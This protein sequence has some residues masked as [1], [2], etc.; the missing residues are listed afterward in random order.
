[1]DNQFNPTQ[2]FQRYV[3]LS[4]LAVSVLVAFVSLMVLMKIADTYDLE[5]KVKSIEY[6]IRIASVALGFVIFA[7]LY[8][9][10]KVNTYMNEVAAELMTKVSWPTV[11]ETWSATFIVIIT[12]V[13]SGIMLGVFDFL[14]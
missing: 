6:V 4:Y 10:S 7:V 11:R 2:Q 12:V 1:M 8:K 9:N 3:N 5:S 14:W 13:L